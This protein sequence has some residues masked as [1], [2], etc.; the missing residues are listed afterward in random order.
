MFPRLHA[1]LT[2]ASEIGS[3]G[4][5]LDVSVTNWRI[6]FEFGRNC[7]KSNDG[8]TKEIIIYPIRMEKLPVPH[9]RKAQVSGP[10]VPSFGFPYS[11]VLGASKFSLLHKYP[12]ETTN[13]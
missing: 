12:H 5:K 6:A 8:R 2:I 9:V 10:S 7:T 1:V 13:T 4:V 11:T 3:K